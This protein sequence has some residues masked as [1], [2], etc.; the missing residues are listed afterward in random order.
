MNSSAIRP[1][2]ELPLDGR[3]MASIH[4]ESLHI[5]VPFNEGG[6]NYHAGSDQ[7]SHHQSQLEDSTRLSRQE[8]TKANEPVDA[9]QVVGK[10]KTRESGK[11]SAER[12]DDS[13]SVPVPQFIVEMNKQYFLTYY[14]GQTRVYREMVD[15]VSKKNKLEPF[16][17]TSFRNL[18]GNHMVKTTVAGRTKLRPKGNAWLEHEA[19]RQYDGIVMAPLKHVPGYYNRWRGFSVLPASGS[20]QLMKDHILN[21]ICTKDRMLYAYVIRWIANMV[22]NPGSP[23]HVALVLK[24]GKGTGKGVLGNALCDLLGQH[25]QHVSHA[26][27]VSGEFNAHLED[28][29]FL[30][31]DE[32]FCT[33][34]KQS[35]QALKRMITE[36]ELSIVGK[37]KNLKSVPNLLHVLMAS[38]EEWVVPAGADERRYCVLNVSDERQQ[39]FQYFSAIVKEMQTGGLAAM[40]YDLQEYDLLDFEVRD[41][42][43]TEGLIEQKKRTLEAVSS[44]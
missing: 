18:H 41:V 29:V 25:S 24:G 2:P 6:S 10:A 42:P 8:S 30:F 36:P 21:N 17:L 38:N 4:W 34:N 20:W 23:G 1:A 11:G 5:E 43:Q 15:P 33:G 28:C 37:G 14:D 3:R 27:H 7:P 19:R 32:A 13:R 12:T 9:Q 16:S 31:A 39:D 22:Q 35:E 44:R 26:N 40:L